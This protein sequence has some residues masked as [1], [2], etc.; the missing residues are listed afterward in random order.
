V[1]A[2]G[3]HGGCLETYPMS[4]NGERSHAGE[5]LTEVLEQDGRDL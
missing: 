2:G 5:I 3:G 4:P 1:F